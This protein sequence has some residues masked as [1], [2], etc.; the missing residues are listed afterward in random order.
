MMKLQYRFVGVGYLLVDIIGTIWVLKV[1]SAWE[2]VDCVS[3]S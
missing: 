2:Y 1:G 3:C